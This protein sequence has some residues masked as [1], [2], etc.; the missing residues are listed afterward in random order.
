MTRQRK[1]TSDMRPKAATLPSRVPFTFNLT[2]T[3]LRT[4]E[5]RDPEPDELYRLEMYELPSEARQ[6]EI[7]ETIYDE[8][9]RR[10]AHQRN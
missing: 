6:Q 10:S 1:L 9:A 3:I 4:A 5:G 8:L 7:F 2:Q